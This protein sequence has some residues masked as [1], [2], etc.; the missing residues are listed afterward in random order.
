MG[1]PTFEHLLQQWLV[2]KT[3]EEWM[4]NTDKFN[5]MNNKRHTNNLDRNSL[6][7]CAQLFENTLLKKDN[8]SQNPVFQRFLNW[9]KQEPKIHASTTKAVLEILRMKL[10]DCGPRIH[11]ALSE[12]IAVASG[13]LQAPIKPLSKEVFKRML[14][15]SAEEGN[16]DVIKTLINL[17]VN[18]NIRNAAGETPLGL[19]AYNN[20]GHVVRIMLSAGAEVD[21]T[22]IREQSPLYL[23]ASMGNKDVVKILLAEKANL[24]LQDTDGGGTPLIT[25]AA[26]GYKD[27][28]KT[29]IKYK[30][31]D[32]NKRSNC[33]NTA[34]T[35]AAF[36]G[37]KDIVKMLLKCEEIKINEH[38]NFGLTALMMAALKGYKN[39]A[40]ILIKC[41]GIDT[42]KK[43]SNADTAIL[44][45]ATGGYKDIVE[46]LLNCNGI[47]INEKNSTS[48]TVLIIAAGFGYKDIVKILLNC[49]GIDINEKNISGNT[50]LTIAAFYGHEDIVNMLLKCEKININERNIKGATAFITAAAQGHK[51]IVEVFLNRKEINI[52]ERTNVGDTALISAAFKGLEDIVEMLIRHNADPD[53]QDND[54]RT[55]LIQAAFSGQ[56]EVVKI[57]TKVLKP[58]ELLRQKEALK[59]IAVGHSAH[60]AGTSQQYLNENIAATVK[61]E[62]AFSTCWL[63]KMS[64]ATEAF[65]HHSNLMPP[66]ETL[67]FTQFLE[68]EINPSNQTVLDRIDKGLPALLCTGFEKHGVT[69]VFWGS[70]FILCDRSGL[71]QV[72]EVFEFDPTKLNGAVLDKIRQLQN[73]KIEAYEKLFHEEL[74]VILEFKPKGN[75]EKDLESACPL[76]PQTV[77]N[78]SWASLEGAVW[79]FF[80]LGEVKQ[81]DKG[82]LRLPKNINNEKFYAW[83][84]FNQM[85]H[86]ERYLGVRHLRSDENSEK[87]EKS[88]QIRK[89]SAI[90]CS[91][92]TSTLKSIERLKDKNISTMLVKG[93]LN[94]HLHQILAKSLSVNIDGVDGSLVKKHFDEAKKVIDSI[95]KP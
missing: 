24:N 65:S 89:V 21:M 32:I 67:Q 90:D 35:M 37:Y 15:K 4:N 72:I 61:L 91:L 77:G 60:L 13:V 11:H 52:N 68:S 46:I 86:L 25:A 53:I 27:I 19:A 23:A 58:I 43:S 20:H 16:V 69:V 40:E 28:V 83:L 22:N 42:N 12:M 87:V 75:L 6:L 93:E 41:N 80:S 31:I 50:A 48:N 14:F 76:L 82:Q 47:D 70:Y 10:S 85:Y 57:L 18:F 2:S 49:K 5:F 51:D 71:K 81:D 3:Q 84:N 64:K 45:A 59:M 26:N 73:K 7:R 63:K 79:T 29:L 88:A 78:C 38:T 92:L 1:S 9:I 94:K 33:G 39:I 66:N 30:G 56:K 36:Y 54:G 95:L 62:G 17:N 44:L 34:L 74:P 8:A 55:A